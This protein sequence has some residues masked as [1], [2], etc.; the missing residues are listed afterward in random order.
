MVRVARSLGPRPPTYIL[1]QSG[2]LPRLAPPAARR[3]WP[4]RAGARRAGRVPG[5]AVSFSLP[6]G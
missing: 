3:V 1:D 5:C 4:L 2:L 6:G